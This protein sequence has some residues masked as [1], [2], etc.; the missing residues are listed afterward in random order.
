MKAIDTLLLSR[1]RKKRQALP[2]APSLSSAPAR[3][4]ES[5]GRAA[6]VDLVQQHAALLR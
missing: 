5:S 2:A 6:D 4:A 3:W 1:K